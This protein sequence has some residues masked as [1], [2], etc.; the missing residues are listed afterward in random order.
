MLS[1][2]FCF[3][4]ELEAYT[5]DSPAYHIKKLL[6]KFNIEHFYKSVDFDDSIEPEDSTQKPYEF[7]SSIIPFS[8]NNIQKMQDFII[9]GISTKI[10]MTNESCGFHVHFSWKHMTLESVIWALVVIASDDEAYNVFT[11]MPTY[12]KHSIRFISDSQA[13]TDLLDRIRYWINSETDLYA[14]TYNISNVV[15]NFKQ[16]VLRIHPQGTL[17]WRGPREF[18][19]NGERVELFTAHLY[20]AV[21]T[22]IKSLNQSEVNIVNTKPLT[23]GYFMQNYK[24]M[25]VGRIKFNTINK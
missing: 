14:L 16:Y 17:E 20:K 19:Q 10:I 2:D 13:N 18:M 3:G 9:Q 21:L 6:K 15:S 7:V 8:V 1:T 5:D 23:K 11:Q 22:I 4:F 12:G 24:S 25:R